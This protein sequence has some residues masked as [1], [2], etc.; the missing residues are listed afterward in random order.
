MDEELERLLMMRLQ[1]IH[2]QVQWMANEEARSAWVQGWAARGG[3]SKKKIRL[4]DEADKI[5]RKLLP[6]KPKKKKAED[7]KGEKSKDKKAK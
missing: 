2:E 6:E 5:L 4:I 1:H 7:K 3:F